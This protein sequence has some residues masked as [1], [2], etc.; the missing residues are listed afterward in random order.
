MIVLNDAPDVVPALDPVRFY[1]AR[2]FSHSTLAPGL[3]PALPT[4]LMPMCNVCG[5][6]LYGGWRHRFIGHAH[7]RFLC[8]SNSL[9][10]K[11]RSQS[12]QLNDVACAGESR[13]CCSRASSLPKG[14]VAVLA[15]ER[16]GVR[17][18]ILFVLQQ[19]LVAVKSSVTE[20]TTVA[21]CA[22]FSY[23]YLG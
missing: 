15:V 2:G 10:P 17:R 18:R 22:R 9:L 3:S 19:S 20:N 5:W 11:D 13:L 7:I 16:R 1:F 23:P 6:R 14:S 4:L 12:S 21:H 8:I